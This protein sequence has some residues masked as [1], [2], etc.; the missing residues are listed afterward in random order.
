M[1]APA[2]GP[3]GV[4]CPYVYCKA[5]IGKPCVFICRCCGNDFRRPEPHAARVRLAEKEAKNG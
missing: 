1:T 2:K 3:L 5:A 4:R